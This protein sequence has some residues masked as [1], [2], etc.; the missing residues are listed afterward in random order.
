LS[1]HQRAL[2]GKM[3]KDEYVPVFQSTLDAPKPLVTLVAA[4]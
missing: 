2:E 1:K 4:R 3:M